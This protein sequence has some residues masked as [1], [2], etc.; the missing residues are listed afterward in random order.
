MLE[1][2][3]LPWRTQKKDKY[4]RKLLLLNLLTSLCIISF[5]L[6]QRH[7]LTMQAQQIN[8]KTQTLKSELL[9]LQKTSN[10]LLQKQQKRMAFKKSHLSTARLIKLL[11]Q[12]SLVIPKHTKLTDLKLTADTLTLS[13]KTASLTELNQFNQALASFTGYT[14]NNITEIIQKKSLLSFTIQQR[15]EPNAT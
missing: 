15:E 9:D 5:S 11:K 6:Y 14:N 4:Y 8:L 7:T 13:G 2:N 1:L 12:I 10:S 3:F